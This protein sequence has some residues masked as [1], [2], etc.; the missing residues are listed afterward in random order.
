MP[1]IVSIYTT[2]LSALSSKELSFIDNNIYDSKIIYSFMLMSIILF[3]GLLPMCFINC[4]IWTCFFNYINS[5]SKGL[6]DVL[7]F[8]YLLPLARIYLI[9]YANISKSESNIYGWPLCIFLAILSY[10]IIGYLIEL[11]LYRDEGKKLNNNNNLNEPLLL[12]DNNNNNHY[13]SN[14]ITNKSYNTGTFTITP[15]ILLISLIIHSILEEVSLGIVKNS[16]Q[17]FEIFKAIILRKWAVSYALGASLYKLGTKNVILIIIILIFSIF[18]PLGIYIGNYFSDGGYLINGVLLSISAG[19]YLN[20]SG[21]ELI[22]EAVKIIK[23]H[24]F[25]FLLGVI[26][27]FYLIFK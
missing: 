9:Q 22:L 2:T 16:R 14:N 6:C 10:Y 26:F 18:S 5:F 19:I 24:S 27:G 17:N 7:G 15:F 21:S 23:Y 12:D 13:S 1:S 20:F 3:F 11:G 4:L 8:F 25:C